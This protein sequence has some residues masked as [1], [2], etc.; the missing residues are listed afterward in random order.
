MWFMSN[1][2][3]LCN[4]AAGWL[5]EIYLDIYGWPY[6]FWLA[7]RSFLDLSYIFAGLAWRFSEFNDWLIWAGDKIESIL[8]SGDILSFLSTWLDYA[9][10]AWTWVFN[11]ID[12]V[13][14]I[15]D[16]WWT[17]IGSIVQGWIDQAKDYALGLVDQ[18]EDSLANL[19][20]S[21]DDFW[22]LTWPDLVADIGGLRSSWDS[23]LATTLPGLA[24][25]IGVQDLIESTIRTWFP[26]YDELVQF[27]SG[28]R[29]F[30]SDP[31][32]YLVRKLETMLE[33]FW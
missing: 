28:I 32:D 22:T 4:D 1:I 18:V 16:S 19:R 26:F 11:A 7:A 13:T 31:E 14:D 27:W 20:S 23:F 3:Q 12:N 10:W 8:S 21:W 17:S 30:F 2:I 15:I 33:R 29:D 25:W 24:T 6:P 9:T 5:Y